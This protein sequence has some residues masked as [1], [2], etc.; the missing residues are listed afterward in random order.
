MFFKTVGILFASNHPLLSL[1]V[2][3]LFILLLG[4][5]LALIS[6]NQSLEKKKIYAKQHTLHLDLNERPLIELS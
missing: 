1:S 2:S 4:G 6:F 3:F 5:N